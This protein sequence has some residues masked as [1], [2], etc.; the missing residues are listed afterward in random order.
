MLR[1]Y[2]DE[3]GD[4]GNGSRFFVMAAV[5]FLNDIANKKGSRLVRKMRK[6]M[7]VE[8]LKSNRMTF[9]ERQAILNKLMSIDGL[10]FFYFIA[11]KSQVL[12]LIHI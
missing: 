10:D 1:I 3:S 11:E 6:R 2:I 7:K 4:L 5:V 8:E 12:S 9:V